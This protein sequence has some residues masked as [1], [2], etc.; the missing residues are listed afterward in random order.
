MRGNIVIDETTIASGGFVAFR[1]VR[2]SQSPKKKGSLKKVQGLARPFK[3]IFLCL[4]MQEIEV[5]PY[6]LIPM[7][8]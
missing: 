8:T 4:Q 2:Q 3:V 1:F 5:N 7:A 6:R